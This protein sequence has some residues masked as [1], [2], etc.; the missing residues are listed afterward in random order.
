ME[1][2]ATYVTCEKCLKK[3]YHHYHYYYHNDNC[4]NGYCNVCYGNGY[5]ERI[6]RSWKQGDHAR[7]TF[8]Y[9]FLKEELLKALKERYPY[10]HQYVEMANELASIFCGCEGIIGSLFYFDTAISMYNNNNISLTTT[11][12]IFFPLEENIASTLTEIDNIKNY[13]TNGF[14][15]P[16]T[17]IFY[18]KNN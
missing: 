3:N 2:I 17:C 15:L 13:K 6:M 4:Y 18:E 16:L 8:N 11:C 12:V 1:R 10:D 7:I 5:H 14:I 9:Q